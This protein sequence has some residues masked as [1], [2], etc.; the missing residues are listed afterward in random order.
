MSAVVS[1]NCDDTSVRYITEMLSSH[2][3]RLKADNCDRLAAE[4]QNKTLA[5]TYRE[6]ADHWRAIAEQAAFL[7]RRSSDIR[8]LYDD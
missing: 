8:Q 5:A 2:E 7:E 4:A 1:R 3:Y 6:L